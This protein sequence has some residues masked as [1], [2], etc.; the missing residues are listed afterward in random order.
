MLVLAGDISSTELPLVLLAFADRFKR[1]VFVPGN[2]DFWGKD[3]ATVRAAC[4]WAMDR[5][6]NLSCLHRG[7]V[8][9]EGRR[10]LGTT[11]WFPKTRMSEVRRGSS[12]MQW[13]DYAKIEGF[14]TWGYDDHAKAVRFLREE[15]R[16]GDIVVTHHLPSWRSVHPMRAADPDNCFYVADVED[17][18]VEREPALWMHGH[19]HESLD[20]RIGETRVVC[21]PY[22]YHEHE[23]NPRFDEGLD[24]E[25]DLARDRVLA[26]SE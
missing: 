18:I 20:Y 19:T 8:E 17:L 10:F 26:R 5:A 14:S 11:L 6:P 22:G 24:L 15:L 12:G 4:G 25:P 3:Q 1:V 23:V 9:I 7:V 16:A 13:S 21:N 2:H